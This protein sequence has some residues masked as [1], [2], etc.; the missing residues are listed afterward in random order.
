M[1]RGSVS[2]VKSMGNSDL[3]WLIASGPLFKACIKAA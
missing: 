1:R 3:G 2:S